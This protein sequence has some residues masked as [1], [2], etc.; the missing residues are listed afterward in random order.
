M[1]LKQPKDLR[2]LIA[3]TPEDAGS[4]HS[5]VFEHTIADGL[6]AG[7]IIEIGVLPAHCRPVRAKVVTEG[8]T[9]TATYDVGIMSGAFAEGDDGRTVGTEFLNDAVKNQENGVSEFDC[10]AVT[11]IEVD[12][13]IGIAFSAAIA[14]AGTKIV[15]VSLDFM[16]G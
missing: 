2:Y 8:I 1:A 4:V 9:E 16:A 13:G 11:A 6:G 10:W 12:R 3:S 5:Q 14:G 15:R 7:D